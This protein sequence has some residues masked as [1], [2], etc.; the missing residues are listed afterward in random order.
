MVEYGG[1]P[2][3]SGTHGD[4]ERGFVQL[5]AEPGHLTLFAHLQMFPQVQHNL[6]RSEQ[7]I[8]EPHPNFTLTTLVEMTENEMFSLGSVHGLPHL[9]V[10]EVLQEVGKA[11]DDTGVFGTVSVGVTDEDFG[12]R[13]RSL[14]V[15]C[16]T[17]IGRLTALLVQLAVDVF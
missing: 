7:G 4:D 2:E 5:S 17:L 10:A 16:C 14:C 13:P 15:Q 11:L 6:D 12:T 1:V 8:L 9:T 3:A